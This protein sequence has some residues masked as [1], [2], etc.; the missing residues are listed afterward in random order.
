MERPLSEK[1]CL[2]SS[3]VTKLLKEEKIDVVVEGT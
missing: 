3:R 2:D 1:G